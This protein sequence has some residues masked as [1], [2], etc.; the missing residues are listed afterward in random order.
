[1][2]NCPNVPAFGRTLCETTGLEQPRVL[3]TPDSSG[4]AR[5]LGSPRFDLRRSPDILDA[6]LLRPGTPEAARSYPAR[7]SKRYGSPA[8][9]AGS[10]KQ[11]LSS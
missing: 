7:T 2:P 9:P 3:E 8:T 11:A 4:R 6:W 10:L 5:A 1:V